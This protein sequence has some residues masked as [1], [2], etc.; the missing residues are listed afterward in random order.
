M[1]GV[2]DLFPDPQP[3]TEIRSALSLWGRC[4][5]LPAEGVGRDE[6]SAAG[7]GFPRQTRADKAGRALRSAQAIAAPEIRA[8]QWL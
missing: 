3:V 6:G 4:G 8:F 2:G 5:D 1:T 7:E